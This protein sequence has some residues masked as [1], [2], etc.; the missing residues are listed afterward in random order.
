M[1]LQRYGPTVARNL[2]GGVL[3]DHLMQHLHLQDTAEAPA[4]VQY[5]AHYP[6]MLCLLSAL[7]VDPAGGEPAPHPHVDTLPSYGAALLFE[8][9]REHSGA[10]RWIQLHYQ[11]GPGAPVIV[12][13]LPGGADNLTHPDLPGAV[14]SEQLSRW[15]GPRRFDSSQVR[16]PSLSSAGRVW[17]LRAFQASP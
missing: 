6:T 15:A 16:V 17:G 2:C 1:E 12:L 10:R 14:T 5:S 3:L 7:R 9:H 4:L 11:A 8:V 13:P